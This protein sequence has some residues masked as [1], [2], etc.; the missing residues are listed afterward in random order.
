MIA[1]LKKHDILYIFFTGILAIVL[2][3]FVMTVINPDISMDISDVKVT[4]KGETELLSNREYS[5]LSS[6]DISVNVKLKGKR[7]AI[8]GLK[9]SDVEVIADVSQ[10]SG[11]GENVIQCEVSTPYSEDI[12]VTNRSD[13]K[14][15][16]AVD[17]IIDKEVEVRLEYTGSLAQNLKL[18]TGTLDADR[19]TVRGPQSEVSKIWYA[20]AVADLT[21]L[22]DTVTKTLPL[23]LV[24]NSGEPLTLTYSQAQSETINAQIRILQIVEVP[25]RV[26]VVSGGRLTENEV[27]VRITPSKVTLI[28]DRELLAETEFLNLGRIDLDGIGDSKTTELQFILPSGVSCQTDRTSAVVEVSVK[29][30]E[31]RE[32][33]LP[34]A[35]IAISGGDGRHSV[36]IS[37]ASLTLK[38]RGNSTLLDSVTPQDIS[39]VIKL[40]ELGLTEGITQLPVS[41]TIKTGIN[42]TVIPGDYHVTAHVT[43]VHSDIPPEE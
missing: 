42:A 36:T 21:G 38:L 7:N 24:D 37:D 35:F 29:N 17:K 32:Y 1:W 43:P 41:V 31:V 30:I 18:G 6:T 28:G 40:D 15:T 19:I 34:S 11:D 9:K 33:P 2:W 3:F 25:L 10:I 4:I 5:I 13:L 23:E 12:T 14:I 27:D 16:V 20:K 39:A 8:L 22:D 26:T